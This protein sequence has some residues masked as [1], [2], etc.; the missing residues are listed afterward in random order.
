MLP[1]HV[2]FDQSNITSD[3]VV[4][5]L[6]VKDEHIDINGLYFMTTV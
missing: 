2:E 1:S 4:M 6:V 5:I 3:T